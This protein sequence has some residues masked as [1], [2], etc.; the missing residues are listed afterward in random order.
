[1]SKVKNRERCMNSRGNTSWSGANLCGGGAPRREYRL[2]TP[3]PNVTNATNI[4][5]IAL[6]HIR[7]ISHHLS[8]GLIIVIPLLNIV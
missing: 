7:T 8:K 5:N 4:I 6:D 2:N 1:M 3:L